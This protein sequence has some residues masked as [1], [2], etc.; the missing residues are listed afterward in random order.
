MEKMHVNDH[1]SDYRWK[2]LCQ[3]ILDEP[4][5]VKLQELARLLNEE[6]E[7]RENETKEIRNKKYIAHF[8]G[9]GKPETGNP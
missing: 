3:A 2:Q 5:P 6:L 9:D 7:A 1:P 4:D 8:D